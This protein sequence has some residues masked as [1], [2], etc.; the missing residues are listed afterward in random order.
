M[1]R[2]G[3]AGLTT[4]LVHG[5]LALLLLALPVAP[6]IHAP[7]HSRAVELTFRPRTAPRPAMEL[8][9]RTPP[10]PPAPLAPPAQATQLPAQRPA[11]PA[12]AAPAPMPAPAPSASPSPSEAR[13]GTA[14]P[15]PGPGRVDLFPKQVL[16]GA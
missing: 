9:P 13:P 11:L 4:G 6:L 10:T 2:W 5:G 3:A 16:C 1:S 7:S 14:S 8:T 12:R 15:G